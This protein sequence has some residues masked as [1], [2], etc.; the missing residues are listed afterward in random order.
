MIG[1]RAQVWH[2]T[3][4]RTTGGLTKDDLMLNK[5]GRIVSIKKHEQGKLA[6]TRNK[7]VPKTKEELEQLRNR[8]KR[9]TT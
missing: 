7:M 5:Q 2:G 8:G 9:H 3:A 1:S 6:Y 4:S